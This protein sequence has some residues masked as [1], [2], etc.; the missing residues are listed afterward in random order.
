MLREWIM[1][2][3]KFIKRD[4]IIHTKTLTMQ[5]VCHSASYSNP[6][7]VLYTIIIL[8]TNILYI[9]KSL[10]ISLIW[11]STFSTKNFSNLLAGGFFDM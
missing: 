5:W 4:Y 2:K 9:Y 1:H 10:S 11:E 8:T 3:N 7:I 6:R